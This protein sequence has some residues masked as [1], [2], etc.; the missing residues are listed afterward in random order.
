MIL[1]KTAHQSPERIGILGG[2]FD[3]I[4]IG[5]LIMAQT[6]MRR[7][8]LDRVIFVPANIP[9]HKNPHEVTLPR[10]RLNMVKLA[11]VGHKRFS[12][13]DFEINREGP[14]YSIDTVRHFRE[15]F[16]PRTKLFFLMGQDA[17][18]GLK[19]WKDV[20]QIFKLVKIVVVNRPGF[21]F[22]NVYLPHHSVLMP[23]IDISSSDVRNQVVEGNAI[24]YL[25]PQ[26]VADYIQKHRLYRK[27]KI[28]KGF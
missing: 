15:K 23:G 21:K 2:T 24:N 13:S 19:N 7:F 3:P 20:A 1:R 11:L 12:V 22:E 4:H 6:A 27:K 10:H 9:P 14:S 5:H 17:F 8:K 16:L 28:K 18:E 25:V 26:K